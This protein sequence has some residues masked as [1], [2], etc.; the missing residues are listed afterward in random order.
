M[1]GSSQQTQI[2]RTK[3][4]DEPGSMKIMV[5][6]AWSCKYA[7]KILRVNTANLNIP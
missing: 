6:I 4:D 5:K 2:H 7:I 3:H 1:S